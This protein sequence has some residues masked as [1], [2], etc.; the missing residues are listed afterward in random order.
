MQIIIIISPDKNHPTA[1]SSCL[2]EAIRETI[3]ENS[4]LECVVYSLAWLTSSVFTYMYVFTMS[5]AI[6]SI[7]ANVYNMK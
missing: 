4:F 1:E 3:M 5:T 2:P 6:Q 7:A